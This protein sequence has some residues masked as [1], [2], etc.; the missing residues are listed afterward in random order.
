MLSEEP[1]REQVIIYFYYNIIKPLH[2]YTQY[3]CYDSYIYI[4]LYV[5]AYIHMY[6]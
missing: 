6:T 1:Y 3:I 2:V 4:V 5:Y